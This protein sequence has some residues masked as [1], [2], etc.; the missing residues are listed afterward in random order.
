MKDESLFKSPGKGEN[1]LE[2]SIESNGQQGPLEESWGENGPWLITCNEEAT[3]CF[4]LL[5][6]YHHF[7]LSFPI[8]KEWPKL[9]GWPEWSNQNGFGSA[10]LQ[11]QQSLWD[12]V[13]WRHEPINLPLPVLREA[14]YS[15][16][17]TAGKVAVKPR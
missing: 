2:G 9:T 10:L 4:N 17:A 6:V 12:E 5:P 13:R 7:D 14:V 1:V 15:F 3:A 8:E 16:T 11:V